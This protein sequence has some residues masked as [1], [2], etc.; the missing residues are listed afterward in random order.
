MSLVSMLQSAQHRLRNMFTGSQPWTVQEANV[1]I[2]ECLSNRKH[3]IPNEIILQ[4]LDH[5]SRWIRT[6]IINARV[7]SD[8]QPIRVG[9]NLHNQGEQQILATNPLSQ[10]E[11]QRIRRVDFVFKSR[12]QGWSSFRHQHG[13]YDGSCTWF[14][15]G[16]INSSTDGS[17]APNELQGGSVK[18]S[19]RHEL[20]RNR[21]W[22]FP[23]AP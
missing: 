6:T 11:A 8:K 7:A 15:C 4:I 17:E 10:L 23:V 22:V 1:A 14:E 9:S 18:H 16:L 2:F 20:Q 12:D 21:Q 5:P 3:P 13:T 19:T